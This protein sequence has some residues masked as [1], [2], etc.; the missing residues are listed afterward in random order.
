MRGPRGPALP[1]RLRGFRFAGSRSKTRG[2]F[3]QSESG[4]ASFSRALDSELQAHHVDLRCCRFESKTGGNRRRRLRH[5]N[6]ACGTRVRA[7]TPPKQAACG[8]QP[9]TGRREMQQA[10]TR[11]S[12]GAERG[13]HARFSKSVH[14]KATEQ[15]R[16][17]R[18]TTCSRRRAAD[19]VQQT[20][21]SRHRT[22]Q[23]E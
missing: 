21:C 4:S 3:G 13:D 20:T 12:H 6:T 2:S 14:P 5:S 8:G 16:R 19:D 18:Q 1:A 7:C 17:R 22:V 15:M 9:T 23:Q 11:T 10:T